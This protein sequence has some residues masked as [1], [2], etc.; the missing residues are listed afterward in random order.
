MLHKKDSLLS[1]NR[2]GNP[3]CNF[4]IAIAFGDRDFLCSKGADD[5]VRANKHF[6]TG[7]SQ[8]FKVEDSSHFMQQD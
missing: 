5:I 1:E 7:R 3:R 8:L 4:P 2:L 6:K